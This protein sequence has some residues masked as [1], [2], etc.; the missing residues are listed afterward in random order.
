MPAPAF[1][2][3]T[4]PTPRPPGRTRYRPAQPVVRHAIVTSG[5]DPQGR[6]VQAKLEHRARRRQAGGP[7]STFIFWA[8]TKGGA[9]RMPMVPTQAPKAELFRPPTTF[10]V[11]RSTCKQRS[12]AVSLKTSLKS[13]LAFSLTDKY[14]IDR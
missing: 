4:K 8:Q 2:E 9:R 6:G 1:R 12:A 11:V 14:I 13:A 5:R 7:F 10:I 3:G